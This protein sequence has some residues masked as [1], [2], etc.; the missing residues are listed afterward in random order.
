MMGQMSVKTYLFNSFK[1]LIN[2]DK[3]I[4]LIEYSGHMPR[5]PLSIYQRVPINFKTGANK[6]KLTKYNKPRTENIAYRSRLLNSNTP[7]LDHAELL[8]LGLEF[9]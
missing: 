8:H 1:R 3:I 9:L 4:S 7:L 5:A 6:R 2:D